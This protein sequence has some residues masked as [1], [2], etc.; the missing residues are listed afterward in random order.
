MTYRTM[1]SAITLA[2]AILAVPGEAAAADGWARASGTLRAGP[3]SDYPAI[4]YVDRGASLDIFGCLS[5]YD[6]CDVAVDGERGWFPGSR[7]ELLSDGRRVHITRST[8]A[9]IGLSILSFGMADYWANHYEQRPFYHNNRYWRRHGIRPPQPGEIHPGRPQQPV[10]HVQQPRPVPH[11][12][13][14][15]PV[16][17]V[18]QP[19]PVQRFQQPRPM[20]HVQQPRPVQRFQRPQPA[21]RAPHAGPRPVC[22]DPAKCR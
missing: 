10:P 3:D 2:F 7:I 5:R 13:Q 21:A 6:W 19:R 16:P 15:R 14:P 20:S 22:V 12:Q 9:V 1:I 11:V 17:H 8:A 4:T 18:Q